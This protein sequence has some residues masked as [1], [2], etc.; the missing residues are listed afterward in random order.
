MGGGLSDTLEVLISESLDATPELLP[1]LP[2]LLADVAQLGSS[3]EVIVD[4]LRPLELPRRGALALDLGCGKGVVAL[5]LAKELGL[6]VL[7]IDLF[8]PFVLE[9]R[10]LASQLGV[11]D[12]CR[13][14]HADLRDTLEKARNFDVLIYASLG[15]LGRHDEAVGAL[16]RAV[17][18]GGY[19]VIDDAYL[20][21]L[22]QLDQPG[23]HHY[24]SRIEIRRRLT[25]HGDRILSEVILP[26]EGLAK[27]NRRT[28]ELIRRRAERLAAEHPDDAELLLGYVE[29]QERECELLETHTV[30]AVWLLE[31][32]Q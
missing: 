6:R 32:R 21:E 16:R 15:V 11:A 28:T 19:L 8:E 9:A 25:A 12:L 22:L 7:G 3:P 5:T 27:E 13:F 17:R 24:A 4:L 30:G 2:E 31:R 20:A 10:A 26:Q 14:E 29:R 18:P 1:Y 23:Y